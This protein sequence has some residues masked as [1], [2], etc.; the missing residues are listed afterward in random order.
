MERMIHQ[1]DNEPD[2]DIVW[3]YVPP[4]RAER[5][6]EIVSDLAADDRFEVR[7]WRG[8]T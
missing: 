2:I 1:Y 3:W 5:T 6:R 8:P 7:E 4:V